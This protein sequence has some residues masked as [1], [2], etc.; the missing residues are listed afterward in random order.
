MRL[1]EEGDYH[2]QGFLAGID[3]RGG[4]DGPEAD[5][6]GCVHK[7]KGGSRLL[8]VLDTRASLQGEKR[9]RELAKQLDLLGGET[10]VSFYAQ[11]AAG[12]CRQEQQQGE[13]GLLQRSNR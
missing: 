4:K 6:R 7:R 5:L 10:R 1:A 2:A 8:D 12:F 13:I 11:G 9:G 3:D